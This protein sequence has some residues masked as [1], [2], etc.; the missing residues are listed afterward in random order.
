V[1]RLDQSLIDN[2][3]GASEVPQCAMQVVRSGEISDFATQT[4][5][6]CGCYFDFKTTGQT[7][8]RACQSASDC[9]ADHSACNYGYC[10]VN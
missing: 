1:A 6:R 7:S 10:E 9:P 2:I 3:I 4:G 8:C 5:L